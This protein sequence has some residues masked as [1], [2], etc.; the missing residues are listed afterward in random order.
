[1]RRIWGEAR[2]VSGAPPFRNKSF[3]FVNLGSISHVVRIIS[4]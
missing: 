4:E 3:C 2:M 1:M